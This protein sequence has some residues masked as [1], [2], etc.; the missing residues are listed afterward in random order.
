[1]L[2][3]YLCARNITLMRENIR[4]VW[5][6]TRAPRQSYLV[7]SIFYISLTLFIKTVY[8][9]SQLEL[10]MIFAISQNIVISQLTQKFLHWRNY[11]LKRE[12]QQTIINED[13]KNK[14][15]ILSEFII[16][17]CINLTWKQFIKPLVASSNNIRWLTCIAYVTVFHF[18]PSL[19]HIVIS[20][21][22]N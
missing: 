9:Y 3:E 2:E 20:A 6:I 22:L 1:M 19:Y 15:L 8:Y 10:I 12:W 4:S 18:L 21:E 7:E 17:L 11:I 13:Y 16:N 5:A 14:R